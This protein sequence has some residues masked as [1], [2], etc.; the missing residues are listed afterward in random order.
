M[1]RDRSRRRER[2]DAGAFKQPDW[3]LLRN[4]YRPL[5]I[6]DPE[7]IE[8]IHDTSM[9]ILEEIGMDF[10]LPEAREILKAAG[11][12]VE[13]GSERVRFDRGLVLEAVA[14][15]PSSFTLHARNPER[16]LSVGENHL[17]FIL[18][19]S[20]PNVSDLDGGRRPGNFPDYCDLLR[21]GQSL[22]IVH[23]YG[24]YPVEPV[25]LPPETRHLD[26][27][28]A[29][30]ELG[31]K[32]FHGYSLGRTRICDAIEMTRIAHGIGVDELKRRVWEAR[33]ER[34]STAEP[35]GTK[36]S[37]VSSPGCQVR[38]RGTPPSADTA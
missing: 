9:K 30:V 1:A 37:G 2:R 4:P 27:I 8:A 19:A 13:P 35:S 26:C 3:E 21:L 6:L 29:F 31:D 18:I 17:N 10:L 34:R 11:A 33:C 15:A 25:D 7:Q 23:L 38:R 20:A 5:E 14:K 16:N 22:N 12:E 28:Q 36:S 24:G 32:V